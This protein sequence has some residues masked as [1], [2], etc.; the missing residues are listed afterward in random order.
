[1]RLVELREYSVRG[2][3]KEQGRSHNNQRPL[4][5]RVER[6]L[7]DLPVLLVQ[8]IVIGA[9]LSSKASQTGLRSVTENLTL[10]EWNV[11]LVELDSGVERRDIDHF[12]HARGLDVK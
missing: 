12:L 5:R 10:I 1:M 9:V 6:N 4:I 7:E 8:G 11:G 2:I 3:G